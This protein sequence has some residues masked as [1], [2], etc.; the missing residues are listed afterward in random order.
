M[1]TITL[2]QITGSLGRAWSDAVGSTIPTIYPYLFV[3]TESWSAWYELRIDSWEPRWPRAGDPLH[4]EVRVTVTVSVKPSTDLAQGPELV[5]QARSVFSGQ[6]IAVR[7][8]ASDPILGRMR[9]GDAKVENLSAK[10]TH[11]GGQLWQLYWTGE[12]LAEQ[13]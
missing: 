2:S 5:A 6:A 3:N 13:E 10:S 12:V 11:P 4:G 8:A 1:S 7:N 9:F